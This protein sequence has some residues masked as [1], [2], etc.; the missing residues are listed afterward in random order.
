MEPA[1]QS[2]LSFF[3]TV[4]IEIIPLFLAVTFLS[5]LAL[6]YIKPQAIREKL[7]GKKG[8]TG[9]LAATV[10]GFVTLFCSCS[11]IPLLAGMMARCLVPK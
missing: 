11:T 1:I 10:L 8:I 5:G 7:G 6:E 9:I 2:A 3:I 4:L